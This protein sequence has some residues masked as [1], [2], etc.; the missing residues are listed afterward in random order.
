LRRFG[1]HA[2][3]ATRPKW[4]AVGAVAACLLGLS[5]AAL[6]S[7]SAGTGT[8][9][10]STPGTAAPE[11]MAGNALS[12]SAAKAMD[13]PP[14]TTACPVPT[15][16]LQMQCQVLIN[17]NK[18]SSTTLT[19]RSNA[20]KA[21]DATITNSLG[22]SEL[23]TAYGLT[24]A[25]ANDGSGET[26]AIVDAFGDPN[27]GDDLKAYRANWTLGACNTAVSEDG[28]LT[29]LNENGQSS[30]LPAANGTSWEDETALDVEMVSAI[31]PNC[32][33]DLFEANSED[34]GDLG[35][36]ENSAAKVS[37]FISNSWSGAD[38]PGES[39]FDNEYFNHPGVAMDFASGDGGNP[40]Y[41]TIFPT[42]YPGAS[43]LV[44]SVGGTYLDSGPAPRTY[45]EAVWSGQSIP[46]L[47]TQA[48][49]TAGEGKPSWQTDSGCANRTQNDVSAVADAPLGIDIYSSS[50][51]C[52]STGAFGEA[53]DCAAYGT[54]VA[55]PI[56]TAIYALA[57]PS[58]P[59]QNT[60]PVS[61][62][63]QHA[64]DS[65][66]LYPVAT[67]QIGHCESNREYL[68]NA[69][70]SLSNGYN[71]PTGLGTPDGVGAFQNSASDLVS[72]ENPGSYDLTA[73]TRVTLPAIRAV[74]SGSQALTYSQ[75]GLPAGMSINAASG[76]ISGTM[77]GSAVNDKVTVTVTD[78][79]DTKSVSFNLVGVKA[80][81][82]SYHAGVGEVK[83]V[84]IANTCM[85]DPHNDTNVDAPVAIYPCQVSAS[86]DWSY[87]M[88]AGPGQPGLITIHGKCASVLGSSDKAGHKVIGLV[89]CSGSGAQQWYLTGDLAEI[90]NQETGD[91]LT[92]PSSTKTV[93]TQ[94]DIEPCTGIAGQT[95]VVP[96]SPVT[97]GIAGKCLAESSGTAI[98]T[99]CTGSTTQQV[100]LGLDGSLQFNGE[101]IYN[102][103]SN[104]NDGTA[105]KLLRCS[106]S[107]LSEEWGIS[108]Y[109]QI[110]NLQ[111]QKCLAIP[112]N[113]SSNGA[114]LALEDCYGE[115][116]EVWAAS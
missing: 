114:K 38:Y 74:S 70:A 112:G 93:N 78:G 64:G 65:S 69:T 8:P 22:P 7:A 24:S 19:P 81:S 54:S 56:I 90:V 113:S 99:A 72:I 20:V 83:L 25:S 32:H 30:P 84:H 44:T 63:Y 49:C 85:N 55:T 10:I 75:S 89:N 73:G 26:V 23:Q 14:G 77:P 91:C 33:I 16:P 34:L 116:G 45:Q 5:S 42:T 109:G 29:V 37:K 115:P 103:A 57:N 31:C 17:H 106:S 39:V 79:T 107:N 58:G 21:Q 105:I 100:T 71:G 48:G 67:G 4:L 101:C 36:A 92:D 96:P 9:S 76:V 46:G 53:N 40:F 47:G 35:T 111:S 41:G 62:L 94:L 102:A 87:S 82:S 15:S 60:Y 61:Y 59:T 95:L 97:S 66:D 52:N 80:M 110:E 27:I 3:Q 86:Q 12:P 51:D 11:A 6:T 1:K 98:S 68:C 50:S 18:K 13:V 108:A 88:P 104:P 28:C 2:R 43:G